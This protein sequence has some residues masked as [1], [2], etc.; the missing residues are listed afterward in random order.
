MKKEK[1][2]AQFDHEILCLVGILLI[3][4]IFTVPALAQCAYANSS[5]G[6]DAC[7]CLLLNNGTTCSY[8]TYNYNAL[9]SSCGA[10]ICAC[11]DYGNG[12]AVNFGTK[13]SYTG[14]TCNSGACS[15]GT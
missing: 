11:D 2:H 14:G 15:G 8:D 5:S 1:I 9:C 13:T 6:P 12:C 7:N 10:Q 3:S 4:L